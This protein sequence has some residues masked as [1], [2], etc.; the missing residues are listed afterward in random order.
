MFFP[1]GKEYVCPHC[2]KKFR[3]PNK[4]KVHLSNKCKTSPLLTLKDRLNS[5]PR[6]VRPNSWSLPFLLPTLTPTFDAPKYPFLTIN[7]FQRQPAKPIFHFPHTMSPGSLVDRKVPYTATPS[8]PECRK[9]AFRPFKESK[10]GILNLPA[11]SLPGISQ[12][13]TTQLSRRPDTSGEQKNICEPSNSYIAKSS[14]PP[15]PDHYAEV[16]ALVSNLGRGRGGHI[17]LYC[18]K[19]YSRKYGLKIHIRTHTGYKP[20]SCKVCHR[21]FGDPSN[22]NKHVRLHAEGATPYRCRYC[23]KVLVRRRDLARHLSSRHP[24]KPNIMEEPGERTGRI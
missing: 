8:K 11:V 12:D 22:L 9:S 10:E 5:F 20:L 23:G 13:L 1:T 14:P 16:E 19:I 2:D 17:C 24:D 6:A 21:A 4:L 7:S 3:A 18:G 15:A